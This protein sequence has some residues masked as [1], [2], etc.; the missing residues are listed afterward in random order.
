MLLGMWIVKAKVLSDQGFCCLL[1]ES[2]DSNFVQ[3]I[4]IDIVVISQ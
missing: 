4:R 2:L 3:T 1:A